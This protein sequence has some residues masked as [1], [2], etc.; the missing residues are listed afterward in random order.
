M[1]DFHSITPYGSK[2]CHGSVTGVTSDTT[3]T[4]CDRCIQPLQPPTISMAAPSLTHLHLMMHTTS[5]TDH[6]L[7]NALSSSFA[8]DNAYNL[9]D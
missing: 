1:S 5:M 9:Y 7:H 2:V 4:G 6:Y 8:S 3:V